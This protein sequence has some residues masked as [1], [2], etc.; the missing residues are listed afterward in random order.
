MVLIRDPLLESIAPHLT[1]G[2]SRVADGYKFNKNLFFTAISRVTL[3][4]NSYDFLQNSYN[5]MLSRVLLTQILSK[6]VENT[7]F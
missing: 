3:S 1:D 7:H 6:T 5:P 2:L 4:I